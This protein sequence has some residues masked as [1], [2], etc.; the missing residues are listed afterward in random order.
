MVTDVPLN[1]ARSTKRKSRTKSRDEKKKKTKVDTGRTI[2]YDFPG[3]STSMIHGRP[4]LLLFVSNR[5]GP[6]QAPL[7][8]RFWF[9]CCTFRS[10]EKEEYRLANKWPMKS[11]VLLYYMGKPATRVYTSEFEIPRIERGSGILSR[12]LEDL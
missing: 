12:L 4:N 3:F 5:S 10:V 7:F 2:L 9:A 11:E 1:H 8:E 6:S